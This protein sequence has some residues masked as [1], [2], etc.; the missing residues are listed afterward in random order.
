MH[1]LLISDLHLDPSQPEISRQFFDFLDSEAT[2]AAELFILG[3]LFESWIGDDDP[4]PGKQ[5]VVHALHQ[6]TEGGTPCYFIEG[7]RDFLTGSVFET[8]SGCQRL[9]DPSVVDLHGNGVLLSHGDTL[10][11]DDVDYQRFRSMVRDPLWQQQFL[12]RSIEHRLAL[13]RQARDASRIETSGKPAEIMDVNQSAVEQA[14]RDY[15]VS[16]MIHGHTHRPGI[17]H[18]IVDGAPRTRIVLGDWY[19]EGSVLRWDEDGY[20][21]LRLPR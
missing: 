17:H 15:G 19:S 7:N 8:R 1:S 14:F 18:L 16:T 9:A 13:V 4:D 10:C 11:T 6:L 21:L 12:E 20:R 5:R 2:Q 3:D